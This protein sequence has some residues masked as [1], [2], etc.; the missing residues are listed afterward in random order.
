MTIHFFSKHTLP[1][2]RLPILSVPADSSPVDGAAEIDHRN[3]TSSC[4]RLISF[5]ID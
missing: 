1:L 3:C 4:F 2:C 5:F